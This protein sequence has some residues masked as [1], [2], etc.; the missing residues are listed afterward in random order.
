MLGE[1]QS[2]VELKKYLNKNPDVYGYVHSAEVVFK[3]R[4]PVYFES[5]TYRMT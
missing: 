5:L 2:S 4:E 3:F 1:D